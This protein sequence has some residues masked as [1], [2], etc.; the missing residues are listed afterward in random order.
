M[1][2]ELLEDIQV[3]RGMIPRGSIYVGHPNICRALIAEGK[4]RDLDDPVEVALEPYPSPRKEGSKRARKGA[5]T[6]AEG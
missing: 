4:A 6:R 2:V 3:V 1:E 5:A